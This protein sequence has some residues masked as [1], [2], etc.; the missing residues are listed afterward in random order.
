MFDVR[1][2]SSAS[3]ALDTLSSSLV[4]ISA[5]NRLRPR[6]SLAVL[7]MRPNLWCYVN[8]F[9]SATAAIMFVGPIEGV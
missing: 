5:A 2:R 4:Y 9:T 6:D 1:S 8:L 3:I 7:V